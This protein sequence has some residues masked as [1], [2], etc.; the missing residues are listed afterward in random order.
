[1]PTIRELLESNFNL[2]EQAFDG[3]MGQLPDW[4]PEQIK[5]RFYDYRRKLRTQYP[6]SQIIEWMNQCDELEEIIKRGLND[7]ISF[8]YPPPEVTDETKFLASVRYAV[9]LEETD[10]L[11]W[12]A[13]EQAV[14]GKKF[15]S[16]GSSKKGKEQ[17]PT[18]SIRKICAEIASRKFDDV[19][20]ALRDAERCS[21]WYESTIAPTG[22]LITGVDD[23]K[24]VISYRPRGWSPDKH[25]QITFGTLRNILTKIK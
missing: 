21:D 15:S 22:I 3:L 13:G 6:D 9:S 19:I 23:E 5:T 12:L 10:G 20:R 4:V 14:K 25:K 17:E 16:A 11:G 18:V 1:M 2:H 24:E 7:A 8:N